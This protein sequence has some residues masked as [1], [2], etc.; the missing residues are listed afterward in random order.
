VRRERKKEREIH[1]EQEKVIEGGVFTGIGGG[2]GGRVVLY[3]E[4]EGCSRGKSTGRKMS[5]A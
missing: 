3:N 4:K 5:A 1:N 2:G